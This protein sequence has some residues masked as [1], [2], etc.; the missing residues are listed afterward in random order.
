MTHTDHSVVELNRDQIHT[1]LQQL[2]ASSLI[3]IVKITGASFSPD[4][5]MR[6]GE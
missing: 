5:L 1:G 4:A 6:Q 3:V 2:C